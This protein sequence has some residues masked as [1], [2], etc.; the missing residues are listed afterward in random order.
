MMS[1]KLI[2]KI[3]LIIWNWHIKNPLK[4]IRE[5]PFFHKI[6]KFECFSPLCERY[7]LNVMCDDCSYCPI[8]K[9]SPP[10]AW[11]SWSLHKSKENDIYY[12]KQIYNCIDNW[13]V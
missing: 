8:G 5:A 11:Y 7:K 13:R 2:K 3:E 1:K 6:E 9:C 4:E 10:S 12:A